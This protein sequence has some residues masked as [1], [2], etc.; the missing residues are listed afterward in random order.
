M[1]RN[2]KIPTF[3]TTLTLL[4][5]YNLG[6]IKCKIDQYSNISAPYLY[7]Q[8]IL[9]YKVAYVGINMPKVYNQI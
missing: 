9:G 4:K 2:P 1:Y 8:H 3:T 5:R 7:S 6:M